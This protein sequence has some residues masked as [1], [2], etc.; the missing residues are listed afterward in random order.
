MIFLLELYKQ[1]CSG[2]KTMKGNAGKQNK[3][4]KYY[5]FLLYWF[6]QKGSTSEAKT[7][8]VGKHIFVRKPRKNTLLR[9][10][11]GLGFFFFFFNEVFSVVGV[12]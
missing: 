10:L 4:R 3:T 5:A 1:L 11:L 7:L 9:Y 6:L 12:H 8:A 2:S